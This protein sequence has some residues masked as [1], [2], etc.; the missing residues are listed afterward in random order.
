MK[1]SAAC[2]LQWPS[3]KSRQ[4]V[5]RRLKLQRGF[6][7]KGFKDKVRDGSRGVGVQLMN[8]VGN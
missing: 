2:L 1:E 4:L 8:I 7:G 3:K 5:L 6:S